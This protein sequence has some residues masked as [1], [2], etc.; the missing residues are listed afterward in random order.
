MATHEELIDRFANEARRR[1]YTRR[2]VMRAGVALGLSG[3]AIQSVLAR[4][5]FA[6]DANASPAAGGPVNVPIVGKEM[7]FD[8]IKAAIAEEKEVNVGN[9]TYSAN[10]AL[11]KRFQ[12]YIKDVY[13]E[14]ITLNYAGS[15]TPS[16][17]ITDL[18]IAVGAGDPVPGRA[19][20]VFKRDLTATF[21][22]R[23]LGG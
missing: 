8:D 14:D 18:T 6:Q 16:T 15:Q 20:G 2:Q 1:R 19:I 22:P 21:E 23:R 10:D 17:Y 3:A 5:A 4:P 12:D 11:I 13:D 9:W 7:T